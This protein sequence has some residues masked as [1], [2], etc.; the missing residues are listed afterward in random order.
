MRARGAGLPLPARRD[1][2]FGKCHS[3]LGC[4]ACI[5]HRR[6]VLHCWLL[7]PALLRRCIAVLRRHTLENRDGASAR[8]A[9]FR[10]AHPAHKST[11]IDADDS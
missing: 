2:L 6:R 1:V 10:A 3:I 5:C 7:S 4:A 9:R 8:K 11:I